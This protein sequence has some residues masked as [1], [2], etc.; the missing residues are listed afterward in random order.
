ML[1]SFEAMRRA[2]LE[3]TDGIVG[4]V[5]DLYFDGSLWQVRYL[6]VD[7]GHWLPGKRVLLSPSVI[8]QPEWQ[9][10]KVHVELTKEQVRAAP[11]IDEHQ[12]VSRQ[13]EIELMQHYGWHPYWAIGLDAAPPVMLPPAPVPLEATEIEPEH[14]EDADLRSARE[15]VGYHVHATDGDVGYVE[16]YLIDGGDW[17]IRYLV[18]S[19]RHW[20][21]GR[22]FLLAASW[23][24]SISWDRR[25]VS[26]P[27]TREHLEHSPPYE[28]N[29]PL[30]REYEEQ[31]HAHFRREG[32]W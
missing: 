5:K 17:N 6:V 18:A 2:A 30:L 24:A 22:E 28:K 26:V 11:D 8:R 20:L 14:P 3:G 32:Y 29:R 13:H 21:P 27:F 7:T 12:P 19:T 31:L 9:H 1:L 4:H 16:N 10:D 23:I 25:E 15:V